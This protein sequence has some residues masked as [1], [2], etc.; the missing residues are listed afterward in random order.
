MVAMSLRLVTW[1]VNGIRSALRKGFADWLRAESPDIV[2]LQEVRAPLRELQAVEPLLPGYHAAW[3]PAQRPGYAGTAIL[4]RFAPGD[5]ER[6]LAGEGDAEG[7]ALTADF[8]DFRVM[9]LY[10]PNA[11]PATPKMEVKRA[12][13]D[14]LRRHAAARSGEKPLLV[15]GDLNVARDERDSRGERHPAGIN[16]CTDEERE[17]LARLLDGDAFCDPLREAAGE[18]LLGTWWFAGSA[19]RH[20]TDGVR[21]DYI[22]VPGKD[23]AAASR[24]LIRTDVWGSDHCP[25]Q[26]E[27]AFATRGLRPL[28]RLEQGSLI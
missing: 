20:P 26:M 22:L 25:V 24:P 6:G 23:R 7:R 11:T 8:G 5:L 3:H 17:G 27:L 4:S 16:G 2:C 12:W 18:A 21:L 9:S 10:A 28:P 15:C 14:A 19:K 13:L 1:N